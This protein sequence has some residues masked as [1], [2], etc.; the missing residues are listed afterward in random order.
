MLPSLSRCAM[1]SVKLSCEPPLGSTKAKYFVSVTGGRTNTPRSTAA[2]S[3][4]LLMKLAKSSRHCELYSA[5]N[6]CGS[7]AIWR[8]ITFASNSGLNVVVEPFTTRTSGIVLAVVILPFRV[9]QA[10]APMR[11]RDQD[12]H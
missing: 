1:P 12:Q 6:S 5:L 11:R 3:K 2:S 7:A 8:S 4:S 9:Q 10:G